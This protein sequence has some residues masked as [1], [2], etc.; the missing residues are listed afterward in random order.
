M[1]NCQ[2]ADAATVVI[3]VHP[4]Y[5]V[6]TIYCS[7]TAADVMNSNPGHYVA[8]L[9]KTDNGLPVKQLKIL[10]PHHTLLLGQVYRL[11]TYQGNLLNLLSFNYISIMIILYNIVN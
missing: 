9:I 5:K 6:E 7:V 8:Q 10:Q 2:A 4:G 1:G 3:I 11:I